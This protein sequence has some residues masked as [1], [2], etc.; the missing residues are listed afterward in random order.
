MN[1]DKPQKALGVQ[2]KIIEE[3]EICR[4]AKTSYFTKKKTKL[5]L[6]AIGWCT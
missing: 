3:K 2:S 6:K 1:W 5:L 4:R